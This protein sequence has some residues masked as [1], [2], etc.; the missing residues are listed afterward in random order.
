[1]NV[2]NKYPF[3]THY[4]PKEKARQHQNVDGHVNSIAY[5]SRRDNELISK[6]I[7]IPQALSQTSDPKKVVKEMDSATKASNQDYQ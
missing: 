7:E 4:W 2:Y 6:I 5:V 1:M 3:L